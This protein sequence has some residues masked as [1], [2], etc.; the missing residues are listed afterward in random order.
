MRLSLKVKLTVL[1]SLLVS[2]VILATSA[3][4]IFSLARQVI[5]KIETQGQYVANE[6]FHEAKSALAQSRLPAGIDPSDYVAL[7][8]FVQKT[9]AADPALASIMEN[10]LGDSA[11]IYYVAITDQHNE[12]LVHSDPHEVGQPFSPATPLS[13]ITQAWSL[14]QLRVIYGPP[15]VFEVVLPLAL[16]DNPLDVRVGVYTLFL[17]D[18]LNN[19]LRPAMRHSALAILFATLLA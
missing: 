3:V 5:T 15:R 11:T 19:E 8:R 7:R 9:L 1:I 2:L 18:Q 10:A 14:R 4:Y 16:G 6:I 13:S 17:R 12:V